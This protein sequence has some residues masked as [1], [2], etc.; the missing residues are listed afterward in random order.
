MFLCSYVCF[1]FRKF[2]L[3]FDIATI[4][5]YV[6]LAKLSA[7]IRHRIEPVLAWMRTLN[8]VVEQERSELILTCT[9]ADA[10]R[11]EEPAA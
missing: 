11:S 9:T 6:R 4:V 8:F 10:G 7:Y 5:V 2:G 1:R 3:P